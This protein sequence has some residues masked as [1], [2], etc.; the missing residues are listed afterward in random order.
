MNGIAELVWNALDADATNVTVELITSELGG[1]EG[2]VV[3]DDGRGFHAT[4]VE[5]LFGRVGGSWKH[6]VSDRKTESG[7]RMLHGDKGEG[8]W[9]AFSIGE[10]CSWESVSVGEFGGSHERANVRIAEPH[11]DEYEW[12]GP[13]D[14][15]DSVGT[16]VSIE[17][18]GNRPTQLLGENASLDLTAILALYLTMYP[19]VKVEYNGSDLDVTSLIRS[20]EV[21]EIEYPNPHGIAELVVLEWSIP[22][23]RALFLCDE[24]SA[25]LHQMN[26]GIHAPGYD[27]SAY[28]RWAG[29]RVY[30]SLLPLADLDSGEVSDVVERA[31]EALRKYFRER[32][33]S[34]RKTIVQEW[35]DE[36][37]YPY[38]SGKAAGAMEEAEQ[39][40][41]NFVAVS[42]SEAVNRIEDKTAKRLSLATIKLAVERDPGSLE[43]VFREVLRL[44][45]TKLEE[46]RDLIERTS[47]S[48]II[49]ATRM[50]TNRLELINSLQTL[51]FDEDHAPNVLERSHLH[52]IVEGEPWL[53]G[54]EFATHVSDRGL[55][56]LLEAHLEI[57]GRPKVALEPV[58]DEEGRFRRI[59]FMFGRSLE[60]NRGR[61]E[62]LVVEIK[63]P[64][65]VLGRAEADQIED[66]MGAV[67]DSGRFDVDSTAW[68]FVLVGTSMEEVV[69]RRVSQEDKPKG[70]MLD[71]P[72]AR[73]WVKTW[74]EILDG[75]RHRLAFIKDHLQYD[76]TMDQA[77]GYLKRE[78]PEYLPETLS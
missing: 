48:A 1:L 66:Y 77:V 52:K 42:A 7:N 64:T 9:K 68:D 25:T 69:R 46:L 35:Q 73:V 61:R 56:A 49:D 38:K 5:K 67:T 21:I 41:F 14:T 58:T 34:D 3:N 16:R 18:G 28:I 33:R 19:D 31:R 29:F 53:F 4:D 60:T 70:L 78:Y 59:D 44:P 17:V 65:V 54:E 76:P 43:A 39:A 6:N 11:L 47:L 10:K 63:R 22:M 40:L 57:L 62:H 8:R 51:L 27:F 36:E 55:T 45:E 75:C 26:V 12:D 13:A 72:D 37:V 32:Q 24:N 74:A 2:V 30:E 50:V 20:E 15:S 71:N 23:E